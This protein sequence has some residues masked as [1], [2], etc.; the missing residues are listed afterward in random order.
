MILS[1]LQVEA[2][3]AELLTKLKVGSL[4]QVHINQLRCRLDSFC[5]NIGPGAGGIDQLA[6]VDS[7]GFAIEIQ[8][9]YIALVGLF[10]RDQLG[11]T[12]Q[13]GAM[14]FCRLCH[15]RS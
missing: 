11:R 3:F 7:F 15:P 8:P 2:V 10:R 9:D 14:G 1:R 5:Y 4:Y 13:G 6:A 12:E